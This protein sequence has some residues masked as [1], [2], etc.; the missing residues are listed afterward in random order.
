MFRRLQWKIVVMFVLLVFAIMFIVSGFMLTNIVHLY[1][2]DF[3]TQTESVLSGEFTESIIK[4]LKENGADRSK[5]LQDVILAYSSQLGLD[6]E[7][8]CA[9]LRAADASE[10]TL[11]MSDG[12]GIEN[13]HRE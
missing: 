1:E 4:V 12:S 13:I 11:T 8:K 5:K 6:T 9:I 2:R 3:K 10:I 7:R